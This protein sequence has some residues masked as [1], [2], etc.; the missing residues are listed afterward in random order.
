LIPG[1][2]LSVYYEN[3]R[4]AGAQIGAQKMIE[5]YRH[6]F[7]LD[8]D[9]FT[10]YV[11][12]LYNLLRGELGYSISQFPAKVSDLIM[13]ALPWSIG[14]LSTTTII[15]W[16]LGTILG[17]IAGWS[18]ESKISKFFAAGALFLSILPYYIL[19][20]LLV[21][22][23]AYTLRLFPASGGYSAGIKLGLNPSSILNILWHASLPALSIVLSSLTWWFLSMRSMISTVKGED[24]VLLAEAKGLPEKEIMWKYAMRNAILPQVTG[25]AL[26]LSRIFA[27][28]LITEVI[29]GYPGIGTLIVT[30]IQNLDYFLIQGTITLSIIAVATANL[31]IELLYP[32]ID[33]RIRYGGE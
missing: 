8:K 15:S 16:L 22:L 21:F 23:F 5:E 32:L 13:A 31:L 27:G 9:L 14:L 24:F 7:N 30:A 19:A 3:L 33:P 26:S 18:R 28:A 17:A 10:Q 4:E 2:P 1:D 25:L 6:M 29:F 20:I 11:S 12:F